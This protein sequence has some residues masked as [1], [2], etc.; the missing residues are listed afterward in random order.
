MNL[1]HYKNAFPLHLGSR[2]LLMCLSLMLILPLSAQE[3][4]GKVKKQAVVEDCH[5]TFNPTPE[6]LEQ[7][8]IQENQFQ[9][10]KGQIMAALQEG[11]MPALAIPVQIHI[12]RR[13]DGT[14][15]ISEAS[16]LSEFNNYVTPRY[17]GA[18]LTFTFCQATRYI[19]SDT[20]YFIGSD[21]ESNTMS[22][23]YN[24]PNVMNIYF[25]GDA[26]GYC[27]YAWFPSSSPDYIVIDNS[28]ATNTSTLAHEIGH[29][30]DLYH[31][32]ETTFGIECPDGSNCATA[33]D[34]ICDTPADPDVSGN[35][36][37]SCVYTGGQTA[38]GGQAYMP[39]A[40]NLM[41]Y[42][43]KT[44]RIYFSAEQNAKMFNT[45][46]TSRSYLTY[47]CT[48]AN[49]LCSGALPLSCGGSATGSTATAT[50]SDAPAGCIGG[51]TPTEGVWFSFTGNGQVATV[52]T[53]GSAFDTEITIYEG[54][55]GNLNCIGAND[56]IDLGN[57]NFASSFTFCTQ[58]GVTYYVYLDGFAGDVGNYQIALS[59]APDVTPPAI[60]CPSNVTVNNAPGQCGANVSYP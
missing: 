11:R 37:G 34:R 60:S 41:S 30:F 17:A 32:H 36:N 46:Q 31:T 13:S 12:V 26:Q 39:D 19:D 2:F 44:C 4:I 47:G 56:D 50:D 24:V 8:L 53:T 18:N 20:Y 59:C 38:C 45:A 28:C 33:G 49:D 6:E 7:I 9:A 15:G 22:N 58:N 1:E 40:Q 29:Y 14:G 23:T 43:N 55:C 52:N 57:G 27:G 21:A 42:S 3:T 16:I 35:V 10:R 5:N 25:V 51:G 54:S 48:P